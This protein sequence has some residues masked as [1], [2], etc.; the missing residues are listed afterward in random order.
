MKSQL[1]WLFGPF[2]RCFLQVL[3][4]KMHVVVLYWRRFGRIPNLEAPRTFNEKILHR[5]L[6]D[7]DS[8]M[9]PLIDKIA[10]KET[11]AAR[12]GNDFIIPTLATFEDER[13]VDFRNL[14]YPCVIKA[15]HSSG[16]N[17]FLLKR[18]EVEREARRELHRFL[19]YDHSSLYEEWAYLKVPHRILVEPLI[20]GGEHGLVDYKFHTFDGQVYAIQVDVD[21]HTDHRR[22]F[23]DTN[24][25]KMRFEL[26]YPNADYEIPPPGC[27]NQM[28]WYAE[29]IGETFSYVRADLY[30]IEGMVKFGEV[31]FYH[32]A[33]LERFHP[34]K[35]DM[36]FGAH[37]KNLSVR[38]S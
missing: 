38:S 5:M 20:D 1:K 26:L 6:Y 14:P 24:W 11:M 22:C 19:S 15:A 2:W 35:F 16:M 21:R 9:P 27:L 17:M 25:I 31:T 3:P 33:G 28:L 10:V 13:D 7:R 36:M 4:A 34:A 18:P 32:G 37:W 23:Y 8:R 29:R 12:F 30:E